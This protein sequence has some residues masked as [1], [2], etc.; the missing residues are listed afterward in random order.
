M[1]Y[2]TILTELYPFQHRHLV[3]KA[4]WYTL[5]GKEQEK[6]H[7][8]PSSQLLPNL[9]ETVAQSNKNLQTQNELKGNVLLTLWGPLAHICAII[10]DCYVIMMW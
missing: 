6:P 7:E 4:I 5:I 1:L 9:S 10:V 8:Q 3:V 2:I